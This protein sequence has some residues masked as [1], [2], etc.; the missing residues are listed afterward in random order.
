MPRH[1]LKLYVTGQAPSSQ[2]ALDNVRRLLEDTLGQEYDLTVI[3]VLEQPQLAEQDRV[4]VT[5]TLIKQVPPPAR[6]V[7]GDL[8]DGA[9]VRWGLQV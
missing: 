7:L 4:L 3:D 1:E 5:P 2:R 6:R 8:S 9:R